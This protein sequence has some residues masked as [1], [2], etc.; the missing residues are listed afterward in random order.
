MKGDPCRHCRKPVDA[1]AGMR[2]NSCIAKS[3]P[4]DPAGQSARD[5]RY[6]LKNRDK[7]IAKSISW[8]RSHPLA[9]AGRV[10]MTYAAKAAGFSSVK[11]YRKWLEDPDYEEPK[12]TDE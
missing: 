2:C 4:K 5:L 12:E 11:H 10:R 7:R 3:R 6:Y 1:K 9:S 8:N